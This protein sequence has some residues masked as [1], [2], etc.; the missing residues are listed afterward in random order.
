MKINFKN[1]IA[2]A[3]KEFADNI[4][5]P[6]FLVLI[7]TFTL[8]VF[9]YSYLMG[10]EAGQFIKGSTLLMAGFSGVVRLMGWFSPLIGIALG[11]D[12]IVKEQKSGSLNVLLTHPVFR[13]NIIIGKILGGMMTLALVLGISTVMSVSGLLFILGGTV[14]G[15][16][17]SR[18]ML[19][20]VITFFYSLIFLG[21]SVIISIIVKESSD[22]L[23]YNVVIWLG[24]CAVF[25][26]IAV[27]IAIIFTGQPITSIS[28][29]SF[30]LALNLANI[31]PLYH[32]TEATV[33]QGFVGW[34]GLGS[35]PAAIKG[36]LDTRF[37]LTQW[38][39]EFWMNLT[40]LIVAPIILLIT[41]FIAFLRKDIST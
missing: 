19:F 24:L 36:I 14:S 27:A 3:Q 38:F 11:F 20:I 1:P 16:E 7:I 31:S 33:G 2:I 9:S 26:A 12:A 40:V 41:A 10:M 8:I 21:I 34:G 23:V 22:S 6:V 37:T 18:L 15:I 39:S 4:Q 30:E 35:E 5:S 29:T 13:D 28:S 25:G 17:L 32:Y